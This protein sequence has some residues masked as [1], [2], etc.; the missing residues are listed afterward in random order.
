[1]PLGGFDLV[2]QRGFRPGWGPHLA[3]CGRA[4]LHV[5]HLRLSLVEGAHSFCVL[6]G[7]LSG[8]GVALLHHP[9]ADLGGFQVPLGVHQGDFIRV[10]Q[11]IQALR[12]RGLRQFL[13]GD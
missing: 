6:D 4:L 2:A 12:V 11:D 3:Q 5:L 9:L 7:L 8:G 1:M 10:H 13:R